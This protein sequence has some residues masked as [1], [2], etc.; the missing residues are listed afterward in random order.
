MESFFDEFSVN[1]LYGSYNIETRIT[2]AIIKNDITLLQNL[3]IK[4]GLDST[5]I[6]V[7]FQTAI[8][9]KSDKMII[10]L[11]ECGFKSFPDEYIEKVINK[12]ENNKLL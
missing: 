2:K 4:F 11:L 3:I 6:T 9:Y 8:N 1:T 5:M 12:H 10:F 7:A